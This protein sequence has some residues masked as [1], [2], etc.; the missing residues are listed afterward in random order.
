M[1]K[2]HNQA[3]RMRDLGY[4]SLITHHPS[5]LRRLLRPLAAAYGA[6][7]CLR[8]WLY[9]TGWF[10]RRR[11]PCRVVSVGNLTVGGTGKTPVVIALAEWLRSRGLRIAV[12]SRGY[13]RLTRE[14]FVLV[15]DGKHVAAGPKE[16]GDE[17]YLI[18][19]RCPGVIVAVG[20]DR[21]R[22]GRWVLE[23]FPLD[24]VLL[25]DGFQHLALHRD[26]DLLLVDATDAE[27]LGAL[28]PAGRLREP[29]AAAARADA[30]LL[31]R[32]DRTDADRP[33]SPLGETNLRRPP[34]SIQFMPDCLV[35]VGRGSA[36]GLDQV[37]GRHVLAISGIGNPGSFRRIL[38][39]LDVSV[40][41]ELRF[42]DHHVYTEADIERI[43]ACFQASGSEVMLTTEKDAGKLQPLV[44]GDEPL[45][46][47]RLRT[48]FIDRKE[49]L[50]RL[51][52]G[53]DATIR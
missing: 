21:F 24:Y 22:L 25:D 19:K 38:S 39:Q 1:G 32:V 34:F 27:G 12:L 13:G 47:V 16:A 49:E 41:R 4:A 50:Q 35:H 52:F 2:E 30:V 42:S 9:E 36:A 31:T 46:A 33:A 23:R 40:Q 44:R 11:L 17:P 14:E 6:V 28:L 7:V 43:R 48:E 26:V 37:K 3:I 5:L 10:T 29:V 18:A 20:A 15:S 51:I 8:R 53:A 45:W